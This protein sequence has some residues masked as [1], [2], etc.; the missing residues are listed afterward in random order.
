L[1]SR[2]R[3]SRTPTSRPRGGRAGSGDG[4]KQPL[5]ERHLEIILSDTR[6]SVHMMRYSLLPP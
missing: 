4:S 1:T 2:S 3:H 6:S 5:A